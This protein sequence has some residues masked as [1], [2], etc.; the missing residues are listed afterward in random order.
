MRQKAINEVWVMIT[1]WH[2]EELKLASNIYRPDI[3]VFQTREDAEKAW[4]DFYQDH[5]SRV[6]S[7]TELCEDETIGYNQ[8]IK[9]F[10]F[11]PDPRANRMRF[12]VRTIITKKQL[13]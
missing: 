3:D 13:Q 7:R 5:Y 6:G 12:L 9:S 8:L 10:Y 2:H 11:T 4:T 1:T